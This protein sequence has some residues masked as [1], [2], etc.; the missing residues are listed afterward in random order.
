MAALPGV[1]DMLANR[2]DDDEADRAQS[3][4][5]DQVDTEQHSDELSALGI[6]PKDLFGGAGGMGAKLGL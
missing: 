5:P 2:G 6:D 3:D 4:L 1:I